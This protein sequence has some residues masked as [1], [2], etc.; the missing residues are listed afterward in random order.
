[1]NVSIH[2]ALQTTLVSKFIYGVWR[3]VTAIRQADTDLNPA[4]EPDATWS[5]LIP[6]PPYPSYAGNMAT[7]GASAARVI[8]LA[9]G[10]NDMAVSA[11]WK[12]SNGPDV[13]HTYATLWEVA[14]E[15]ADSRI[16]GGIHYR[17]DNVAGQSA[18]TSV[19][20][21]VFANFMRPR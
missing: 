7:I 14:Q 18:G 4:T 8:A 11:T 20:E 6:T 5:T 16:F 17:F 2:D 10:T 9:I 21:Y 1:M 3:P 15:Q 19:A 13:T 12:Q